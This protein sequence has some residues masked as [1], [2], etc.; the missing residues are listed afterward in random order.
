[1]RRR[2]KRKKMEKHAREG[3]ER[4]MKGRDK[5]DIVGRM[6]APINK[7]RWEEESD[8]EAGAKGD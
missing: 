6:I 2:L 1:M 5:T 8:D 3:D 7:W 4:N